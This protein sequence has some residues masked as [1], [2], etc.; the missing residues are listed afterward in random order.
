MESRYLLN[1]CLESLNWQLA[2]LITL[3]ASHGCSETPRIFES[4]PPNFK[5]FQHPI[6]Y[7]SLELDANF[8][9]PSMCKVFVDGHPGINPVIFYIND[10]ISISMAF[11]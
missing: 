7:H 1:V 8:P 6:N 11:S 4:S 5:L 3:L 9:R 10:R 2:T